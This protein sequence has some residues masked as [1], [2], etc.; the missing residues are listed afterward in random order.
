MKKY[1]PKEKNV[2]RLQI[3]LKKYYGRYS[4]KSTTCKG[5]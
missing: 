4:D 5:G 1:K 3:Y 2:K